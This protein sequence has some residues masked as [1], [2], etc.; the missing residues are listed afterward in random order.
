MTTESLCAN[1]IERYVSTCLC[2]VPGEEEGEYLCVANVRPRRLR[3]H[4]EISSS[5]SDVLAIRVTPTRT[6]PAVDRP[7]LTHFADTWNRQNRDVTAIVH[8]SSDPGRIGVVARRS[9]W[10]REGLPF[11]DFA[12]IADRTI[13]AAIELFAA[14]T[15][16]ERPDSARHVRL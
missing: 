8:C 11:E 9:H 10:I 3:V 13:A 6:F 5:F 12:S 16:V 15:P 2:F 7:G 14:L 1:L 4:L